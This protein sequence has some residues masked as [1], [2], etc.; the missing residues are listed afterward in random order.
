V[1]HGRSGLLQCGELKDYQNKT[2]KQI[3]AHLVAH[4]LLGPAKLTE[5]RASLSLSRMK[6]S[7]KQK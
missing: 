4:V 5:R 3:K 2:E 7:G 6:T 1:D